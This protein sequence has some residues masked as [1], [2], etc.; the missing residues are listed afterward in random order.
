VSRDGTLTTCAW[1][2]SAGS[3]HLIDAEDVASQ[4]EVD[5]KYAN[6]IVI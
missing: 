1:D 3:A 6:P 4:L 5:P 2:G